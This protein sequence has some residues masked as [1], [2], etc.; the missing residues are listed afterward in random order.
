MPRRIRRKYMCVYIPIY[1]HIHSNGL[2]TPTTTT[3]TTTTM[4]DEEEAPSGRSRL[5]ARPLCAVWPRMGNEGIGGMR[6]LD[7]E[8]TP[9]VAK[10]N[11]A[12]RDNPASAKRTRE[13]AQCI[14][15]TARCLPSHA[16]ISVFVRAKDS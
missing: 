5:Y 8:P 2:F 11:M 7:T 13:L 9:D 6:S 1:P 15:I 4:G 3:T 14:C 16:K 12:P 10:Q